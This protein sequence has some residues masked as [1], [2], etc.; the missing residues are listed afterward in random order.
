M[1]AALSADD[2][3]FSDAELVRRQGVSP[4]P[5]ADELV[6]LGTFGPTMCSCAALVR[7]G[8][9]GVYGLRSASRLAAMLQRGRSLSDANRA[10]C[11]CPQCRRGPGRWL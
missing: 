8:S 7:P 3:S 11:R 4:I 10:S 5:S 2:R 9:S 6:R 1:T